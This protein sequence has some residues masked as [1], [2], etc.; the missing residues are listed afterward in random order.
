ML[1]ASIR[2]AVLA[3]LI[4]AVFSAGARTYQPP[5]PQPTFRSISTLVPLDVRVLD[6][7]GHPITD[8]KQSDF[9]VLEDGVVQ[10]IAH[11]SAQPL[12]PLA[13]EALKT[14]P[15]LRGAG[16][17][18]TTPRRRVI[19]LVMG[20]G[21][22]E[23][24]FDAVTAARDFVRTRLMPQ[25][26]V[27]VMAYNRATDFTTD[28]QTVAAVLDRFREKH[29]NIDR[30]FNITLSG[31]QLLYG[32]RRIPASIQKDIDWIFEPAGG[33]VRVAAR[34]PEAIDPRKRQIVLGDM[35]EMIYDMKHSGGAPLSADFESFVNWIMPTMHDA[36]SIH[37]GIEF[38]RYVEGEKRLI[39][40]TEQG[41]SLPRTE[42]DLRLAEAASAA[43]VAIDTIHT[44]GVVAEVPGAQSAGDDIFRRMSAMSTLK[45]LTDDT[46]GH[47]FSTVRPE[48]AFERIDTSTRFQ[49]ALAYYPADQ[50][51]DGRFREVRVTVN[52][53]GVTVLVR[54]GYYATDTPPAP[55]RTR[56]MTDMRILT[57]ASVPSR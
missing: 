38:L 29:E 52:R 7:D 2:R 37:A 53:P 20:R 17:A 10:N 19:L 50:T 14:E 33:D 49:Y 55:D 54:R 40:V 30:R 35:E 1:A 6:R 18:L 26:Y 43:R 27:A 15:P 41:F 24:P 51:K 34:E 25:D 57:A 13:A 45:I 48:T 31:L 32:D 9:T 28:H 4:T 3:A 46:G 12:E 16:G 44:G 22:L 5:R 42:S 21:T 39:F 11:F 23:H 56:I 36:G 8:L 47:R